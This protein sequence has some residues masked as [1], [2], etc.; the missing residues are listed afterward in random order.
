MVRWLL[1]K[2]RRH[3]VH[4]KA[5]RCFVVFED[6]QAAVWQWKLMDLT[7][8]AGERCCT[9]SR[10]SLYFQKVFWFSPT[11][12][13]FRSWF[14]CWRSVEGKAEDSPI[15]RHLKLTMRCRGVTL[16]VLKENKQLYSDQLLVWGFRFRKIVLQFATKTLATCMSRPCVKAMAAVKHLALYVANSEEGGILVRRCGPY[17]AV[18]DRWNGSELVEPDYRQDRATITLDIFSD[19]SWGDEKSTRKSTSSG[20]IFMNG[21]LI[22][23][24]LQIPSYDSSVI[25]WGKTLCCEYYIMVESIYLYQVIQFLMSDET[26]VK[27]RLFVDSTSE[28]FVVQRSG[29][30]RLKHVSLSIKHLFCNNFFDRRCSRSTKSQQGSILP[31]STQ[32]SSVWKDEVF[33]LLYVVYFHMF[34][35]KEK[36][37][38]FYF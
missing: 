17:D 26:A 16:N 30:G 9:T 6:L 34:L 32:R 7:N 35:Q 23:S 5:W 15:T 33:Y 8:K 28:K 14:L 12:A 37:L 20:M 24:I 21:C 18:F 4:W 38:K 36:E 27:Q 3:P 25:T 29:V 22:H 31:I 2:C 10:K 11:T 13:T 1:K 19:P